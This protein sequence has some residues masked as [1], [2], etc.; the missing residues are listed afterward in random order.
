[1][2]RVGA[3]LGGDLFGLLAFVVVTVGVV[4]LGVLYIDGDGRAGG[5]DENFDQDPPAS[6]ACERYESLSSSLHSHD[7]HEFICG[8]H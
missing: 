6:E 8:G 2:R 5:G 3:I 4:T 1:M 7:Y